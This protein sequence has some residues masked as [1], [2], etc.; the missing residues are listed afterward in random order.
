MLRRLIVGLVKGL[1][2]GGGV[3]LL[4]V[5][6]LGLLYFGAWL[7]YPLAILV[8][9]L[10]GFIAGRPIWASGARIEAY[11]KAGV[12]AFL[13][14]GLLFALRRWA[15]VPIPELPFELGGGAGALLGEVPILVL[16]L[17]STV[18]ALLYDFDH[19]VGKQDEEEEKEK[20][21][22]Q[23]KQRV[24]GGDPVRVDQ[25]DVDEDI[26]AEI[27]NDLA[28]HAERKQE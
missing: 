25:G 15:T 22:L 6:V 18:L 1:L 9:V 4:L 12:G 24:A 8:G 16:P 17:I 5:K 11:L 10:T 19:A 2:I 28:R 23:Q 20:V 26:L 21:A 3:G 14:S 7:A 13:A 27:E